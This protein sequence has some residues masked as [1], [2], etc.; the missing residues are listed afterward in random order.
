MSSS[1]LAEFLRMLCDIFEQKL[2]QIVRILDKFV[3]KFR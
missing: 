2:R 3:V 1:N